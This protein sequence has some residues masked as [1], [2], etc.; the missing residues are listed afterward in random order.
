[1]MKFKKLEDKMKMATERL[2]TQF[3]LE[4]EEL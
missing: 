2:D 1:M 4:D 3:C